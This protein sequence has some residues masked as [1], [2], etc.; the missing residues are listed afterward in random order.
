[1]S[2]QNAICYVTKVLLV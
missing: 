2:L 1:L